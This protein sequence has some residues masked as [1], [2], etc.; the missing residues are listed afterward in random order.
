[1]VKNIWSMI[2]GISLN[3]FSDYA[4]STR[5]TIEEEPE[6]EEDRDR[7]KEELDRNKLEDLMVL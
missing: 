3:E 4:V 5:G 2:K 1:M 7:N 6:S